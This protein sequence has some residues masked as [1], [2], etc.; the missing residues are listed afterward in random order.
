MKR[1]QSRSAPSF[2]LDEGQNVTQH[3]PIDPRIKG[4]KSVNST[5]V[6]IAGKIIYHLSLL[7]IAM[8]NP[9]HK[10]R[11]RS[12]GKSSISIRAMA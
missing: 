2:H 12:L 7:N 8:E 11:F 3:F 6:E 9:N 4:V 10:W 1:G 5:E